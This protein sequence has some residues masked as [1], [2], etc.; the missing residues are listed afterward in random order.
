[1]YRDK[2]ARRGHLTVRTTGRQPDFL[3]TETFEQTTPAHPTIPLRQ[4]LG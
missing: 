2:A 3:D 1:M 4:T